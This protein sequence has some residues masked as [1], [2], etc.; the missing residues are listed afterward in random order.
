MSNDNRSKVNVAQLVHQ[1]EEERHLMDYVRVVY[2]RRWVAI[3]VLLAVF[4]I[5]AINSYRTTPLYRAST[6]LL[7]E[8]DSPKV[9]DL[10]TMFQQQDGWYNDD[11][12]QTQYKILQSR[13]LARRTAAGMKLDQHPAVRE[14]MREVRTPWT[15]ERGAQGHM[16]ARQVRGGRHRRQD[17]GARADSP[18]R[19]RPV[20]ADTPAWCLARSA[21]R[22]SA[23]AGWSTSA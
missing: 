21:S 1:H 22:P 19:Q 20:R 23:T 4:T 3:P 5:G 16:G 14:G 6:Q 18:E 7:I 13:S 15:R 10:S 11:F 12:Y 2:K 17:R 8:K 9:G